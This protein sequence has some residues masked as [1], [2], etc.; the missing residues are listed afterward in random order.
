MGVPARWTMEHG[1]KRGMLW[2]KGTAEI[3]HKSPLGLS[4]GDLARA[5]W[6]RLKVA[7]NRFKKLVEPSQVRRFFGT[8]VRA[9]SNIRHSQLLKHAKTWIQNLDVPKRAQIQKDERL[10]QPATS[11][12]AVT[13]V[14]NKLQ[15]S[16]YRLATQKGDDEEKI[17]RTISDS[18]NFLELKGNSAGKP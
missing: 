7:H 14:A 2:N 13:S 5:C 6:A 8:F 4:S 17:I 15:V 10:T 11:P 18:Q 12:N 16:S 1:R 9:V 3:W